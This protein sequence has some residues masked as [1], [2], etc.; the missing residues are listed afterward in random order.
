MQMGSAHL[1]TL[2]FAPCLPQMAGL[3]ELPLAEQA[4]YDVTS[5]C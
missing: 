4:L 2:V 3:H 5:L 1:V